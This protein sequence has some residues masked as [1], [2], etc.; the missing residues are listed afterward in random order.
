M[1]IANGGNKRWKVEDLNYKKQALD[2]I[3]E[4][5]PRCQTDGNEKLQILCPLAGD[6]SFVS[7]AWGEGH[8]VT[9]IDLVPKAVECM[10]RQFGADDTDWDCVRDGS[11]TVWKHNSGRATLYE[12]DMLQKRVELN[13][14][15]DA[16]YDKDSFGALPINLR[17]G[18]CQRLQDFTKDDAIVYIEVKNKPDGPGQKNGPPYH[19]EQSDLMVKN[20]FGS[21]FEHMKCLGSVY[22]LG[23]EGFSQ[24]GHI[25]KR[26]CK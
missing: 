19:V 14:V 9:A 20:C 8:Y 26:V 12:G 5:S 10:R 25:L 11:T 13:G 21:A 1:G 2:F 7:Y 15:F 24:I 18:F 3:H 6:D 4:H 17:Q 22:P 16:V 23:M